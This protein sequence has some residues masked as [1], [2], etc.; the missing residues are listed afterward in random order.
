MRAARTPTQNGSLLVQRR[1][2]G[3]DP[4]RPRIPPLLR[5]GAN[6]TGNGSRCAHQPLSSESGIGRGTIPCELHMAGGGSVGVAAAEVGMQ[7]QQEGARFVG[8]AC[9]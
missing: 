8:V 6:K 1:Y 7:Q 3:T 5:R 9:L 2:G 4:S